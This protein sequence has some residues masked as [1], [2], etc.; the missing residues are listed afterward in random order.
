LRPDLGAPTGN[1][2]NDVS[3]C[4]QHMSISMQP[5]SMEALWDILVTMDNAEEWVYLI[6]VSVM[7]GE[8]CCMHGGLEIYVD[9]DE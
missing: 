5:S 6:I 7:I 4:K 9:A 1:G 8:R 2:S 3:Y